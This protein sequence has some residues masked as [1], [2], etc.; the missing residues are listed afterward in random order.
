MC[1]HGGPLGPTRHQKQNVFVHYGHNMSCIIQGKCKYMY[2]FNVKV[3][4]LLLFILTKCSGETAAGAKTL[5]SL[6]RV[7]S[8]VC[9]LWASVE[10]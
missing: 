6:S 2:T 7:K 1:T 8:L 3:V 9:P 5:K 4:W 10:T